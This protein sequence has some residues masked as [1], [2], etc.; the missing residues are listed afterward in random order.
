MRL[1]LD[2]HVLIWAQTSPDVLG[3]RAVKR[4]LKPA[5][6]V[7]V[8]AISVMELARLNEM[9]RVRIKVALDLWFERALEQ[10]RAETVPVTEAIALEAARLP[11][12]LPP[13]V[14]DRVL[15]ATARVLDC[16]LMTA[17]DGLLELTSA[18]LFD[19]RL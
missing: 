11:D 12:P 3:P 19:A 18:K 16:A 6:E 15:L 13:D 9:R 5:T 4:L 2:T 1:L 17:D 10:L 14:A 8:S 7:M